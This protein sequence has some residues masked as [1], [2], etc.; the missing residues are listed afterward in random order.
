MKIQKH[1]LNN[2]ISKLSML[3]PVLQSTISGCMG[4]F[5]L[6]IL[7]AGPMQAQP[8][9]E[10]SSSS[11]GIQVNSAG[12]NGLSITGATQH[13]VG[14]FFAGDD[15]FNIFQAVNDGFHIY[16]AGSRG[17]YIENAD[18]A[19][20]IDD[21]VNDAIHIK[22]AGD[23]GVNVQNASDDG[24]F[25]FGAG[26]DGIHVSN[27]NGYSLNIWGTKSGPS[28]PTGHIAQM[29]N[30]SIVN[31][32]SQDVLALKIARTT[33]PDGLNNFITFF[34]GNDNSLGSIEGNGSGGVTFGTTGSD[35]AECLPQ[36]D[37]TET[38]LPGDLVGVHEGKIS[39]QTGEAA[40]VMVI[41]DQAAILGNNPDK[42]TEIDYQPVSFIGQIPV[43]V[44]G[45]VQAGDWI[46]PDGNNKGVAIAVSTLAL[47]PDHQI[48]GRAWESS[49]DHGIKRV[50]TA[51]GLDQSEALMQMIK[52]QQ[53]QI[54]QLQQM[55]MTIKVKEGS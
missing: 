24:I 29:Y 13:G 25:V 15:G 19:I 40:Q 49:N 44:R 5:L 39:H 7:P 43:R 52:L 48:V 4:V 26:G 51:V 28:T 6:L 53:Q 54:D 37:K 12:N 33:N 23:D 47:T 18:T 21:A 27:A 50:N 38:F 34:D 42:E 17:I 30:R 32:Q 14:V 35:Y 16:E 36:I 46:V 55:V 1:I 22:D 45:P 2:V 20:M 10:V 41:T 11:N 8:G 9:L 3:S 31:P